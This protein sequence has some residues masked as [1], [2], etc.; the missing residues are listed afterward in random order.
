MSFPPR[1]SKHMKENFEKV[2]LQVLKHEGGWSDHP[3]DPGGAT[4]KG[5]TLAVFR[6]FFGNERSKDDLRDITDQQLETI[7]RTDYWDKCWCDDLPHGIDLAVFDT[8]VNSG[9]GRSIRFVQKVVDSEVDGVI[10]LHTLSR[11]RICKPA[12]VIDDMLDER[13]EFL[14]SLGTW[15]TFG[16][17]WSRR[18]QDLRHTCLILC[19]GPVQSEQSTMQES[20][21]IIRLGSEGEWVVKLQQALNINANGVFGTGTESA[22]IA[23]QR[24]NSLEADG[25]AGRRTYTALGLIGPTSMPQSEKPVH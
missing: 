14:Q 17:G 11:V 19:G 12:E 23:F 16:R 5:I 13:L 9:P 2:L 18:V 24:Q 6:R 3:R 25:V 21:A 1:G 15:D 20:Y 8:A 4:M 10:G 22:L 7:Y